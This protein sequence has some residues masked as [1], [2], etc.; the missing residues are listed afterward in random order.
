MRLALL[1]GALLAL[2]D[3]FPSDL[4]A[5]STLTEAK[6][7]LFG[8]DRQGAADM[9]A[10]WLEENPASAQA[11]VIFDR[12]FCLEQNLAPLLG[13]GQRILKTAQKGVLLSATMTKIARLLEVTGRTEEACEG[14]LSAYA[15]GGSSSD[16]EAASLI[17]LEMN[18][19][20]TLE[21]ALSR[22][23]D[24][25]DEGLELL[26][27]CLSLQ[28]GDTDPATIA[29]RRI[30]DTTSDPSVALKALWVSY[31]TAVWTGNLAARRQVSGVLQERFP[32]S[33]EWAIAASGAGQ[34]GQRPL[35][36]ITLLPLP[37]NFLLDQPASSQTGSSSGAAQEAPSHP[38]TSG[39]EIMSASMRRTFSVQAGS[40][41]V[42]ENADDMISELT[43][44]GFAPF[45]RK[46]AFQGR[47]LY[48]VLTGSHL[49]AEEAL[50]L[51]ER[52]RQSGFS[53]F[54]LGE[55]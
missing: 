16:L 24:T 13:A 34:T 15:H 5:E 44:K 28:K 53:G 9:Y 46:D 26:G 1:L 54:L 19:L 50:T 7:L 49:S 36:D 47:S 25:T 18:D 10:S 35:P 30:A 17:S 55:Q 11:P 41:Q 3:V 42:K 32:R 39:Q 38:V 27:A 23:E 37:G 40:F 48:R 12:Y 31:E 45:L 29:L 2:H 4:E 20:T 33:P 43:R 52:L 8:G 22:M 21:A 51:I 6:L 14:Y